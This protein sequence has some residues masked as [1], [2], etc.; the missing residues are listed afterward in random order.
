MDR[1]ISGKASSMFELDVPVLVKARISFLRNKKKVG[2]VSFE[3]GKHAV[4][5]LVII[6]ANA[7]RPI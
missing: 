3:K 7:P 5:A 6:D 4:S 2:L 1:F